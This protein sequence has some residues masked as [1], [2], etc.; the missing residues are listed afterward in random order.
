MQHTQVS[1]MTIKSALALA[2]ITGICTGNAYARQSD[3]KEA[4]SINSGKQIAE[5][6]TNKI[7]F[8]D[9]VIINQGTIKI[10][11]DKV[12]I[13][14]NEKGQIK[15]ATAFGTPA[16]FYQILDNGKHVTA[17]SRRIAYYPV[18][19]T[20]ELK[21]SA[22]IEQGSSKIT[23]DSITYNI[24]KE[25]MEASSGNKQN[26]DR[27]TTVFVPEELKAQIEENKNA[28]SGK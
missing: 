28:G 22:V 7:T 20:V 13:I 17:H 9:H 11:A 18:S 25:R 15:S 12:E 6:S 4:I 23:S 8:L 3:F 26:G 14:R 5:L 27:V 21:E 24:A 19:Q 1:K 16:T 2:V 10:T